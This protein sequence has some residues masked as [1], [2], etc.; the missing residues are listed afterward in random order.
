M[1]GACQICIDI[2]NDIGRAEQAGGGM[3]LMWLHATRMHIVT[4]F[5]VMMVKSFVTMVAILSE[6]TYLLPYVRV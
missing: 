1:T 5:V 2:Q 3:V 4:D 6:H